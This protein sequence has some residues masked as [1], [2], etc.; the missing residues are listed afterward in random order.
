MTRIECPSEAWD[1]HCE[2]EERAAMAESEH[3]NNEASQIKSE[4]VKIIQW[5]RKNDV[6]IMSIDSHSQEVEMSNFRE[7]Q[8]IDPHFSLLCP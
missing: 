8:D 2:Q 4:V 5:M 1:R 7:P 6:R 3:I